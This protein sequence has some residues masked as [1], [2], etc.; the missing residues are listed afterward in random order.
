MR[1]PLCSGSAFARRVRVVLMEKNL[2]F[3]TDFEDGFRP[4]EAIRPHSPALQVPVLYDGERHLFGSGLILQHLFLAYADLPVRL[5][6]P[7][8]APTITRAARHWDDMQVLTAIESMADTVIS[9]RVLRGT[10]LPYSERQRVRI[11]SCL[12]RLEKRISAEGSGRRC[13]R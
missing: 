11:G 9:V 13:S 3:A 5:E 10:G 7:P 6:D 8:L 4:V 12:D 1:K 2:S